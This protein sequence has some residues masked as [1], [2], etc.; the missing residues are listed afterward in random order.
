MAQDKIAYVVVTAVGDVAGSAVYT[1]G[2]GLSA[3]PLRSAPLT[4]QAPDVLPGR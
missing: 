2:S 3:L 1:N 4:T